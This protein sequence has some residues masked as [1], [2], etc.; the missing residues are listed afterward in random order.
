MFVNGMNKVKLFLNSDMQFEQDYHFFSLLYDV[1]AAMLMTSVLHGI[2]SVI[3]HL[4][5][6]QK[7]MLPRLVVF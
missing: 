4:G 3:I 5:W 1:Y 7:Q 2:H 6:I